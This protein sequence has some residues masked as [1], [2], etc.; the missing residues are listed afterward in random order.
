MRRL[1]KAVSLFALVSISYGVLPQGATAAE[2]SP[3]PQQE[4]MGACNKM[5]AQKE[6]KGDDRKKFMS[7]CLKGEVPMASAPAKRT[8]QQ[9]KMASCNAQA[10]AKSLK[11]DERKQF[12]S[13]CLK[14]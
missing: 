8:P 6:L 4:L 5:A 2:K 13:A 11:G 10:G 1:I 12:M 14:A 3:T 7:A 9:E